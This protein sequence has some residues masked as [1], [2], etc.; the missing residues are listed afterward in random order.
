LSGTAETTIPTT[1]A[2]NCHFCHYFNLFLQLLL[3][4][5]NNFYRPVM[6]RDT[7]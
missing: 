7:A 1:K 4:W 6:L 5:V 2:G 3:K